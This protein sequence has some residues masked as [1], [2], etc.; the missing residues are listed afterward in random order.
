LAV[1]HLREAPT[2]SASSVD[3]VVVVLTS[4]IN[5]AV[6]AAGEECLG[7]AKLSR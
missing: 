4:G 1:A 5:E 7:L 6:A 2:S 3:P